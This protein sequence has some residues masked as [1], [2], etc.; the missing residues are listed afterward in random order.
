MQGKVKW[1]SP[2]KGFGF[3][4][5]DNNNEYFVHYSSI[6]SDGFKTLRK[7]QEVSFSVGK[8]DRGEFADQVA[9][10]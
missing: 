8:N 6:I 5:G 1:F 9:V 7:G 2:P 10:V 4:V 3:I